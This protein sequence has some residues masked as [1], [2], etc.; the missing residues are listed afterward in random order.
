M[1]ICRQD[2]WQSGLSLCLCVSLIVIRTIISLFVCDQI[3][4]SF[5]FWIDFGSF[6]TTMAFP[7]MCM[8]S[9]LMFL[10]SH[11]LFVRV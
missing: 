8:R 5:P 7:M 4:S 9:V 2:E 1:G 3:P 6:L 10:K 11:S